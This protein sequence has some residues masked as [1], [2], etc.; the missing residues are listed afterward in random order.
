MTEYEIERYN[1]I[2]QELEKGILDNLIEEIDYPIIR[3]TDLKDRIINKIKNNELDNKYDF[4]SIIG[5]LEIILN[6]NEIIENS[7]LI[8]T[9]LIKYIDEGNFNLELINYVNNKEQ[10]YNYFLEKIKD[11]QYIIKDISEELLDNESFIDYCLQNKNLSIFNFIIMDEKYI[12]RVRELIE[13][14]YGYNCNDVSFLGNYHDELIISLLENGYINHFER[15]I[16]GDVKEIEYG[17]LDKS[18][19]EELIVDTIKKLIDKNMNISIGSNIRKIG[20]YYYNS[21]VIIPRYKEIFE[22]I[23]DNKKYDYLYIFQEQNLSSVITQEL[24]EK[25][26]NTL[27]ENPYLY[28]VIYSKTL[29]HYDQE[30]TDYLLD[31]NNLSVIN[32][33][34]NYNQFINH[35]DKL[36]QKLKEGQILNLDT[37]VV[38]MIFKT[39][40][41]ELLELVLNNH[42]ENLFNIM[43][44]INHNEN[45]ISNY[46]KEFYNIVRE[47]I[48]KIY[49]LNI[50]H[51]DKFVEK[52]GYE[53]LYYIEN[54]NMKKAINSS[55]IVFEKYLNL[56]DIPKLT[57]SDAR[58]IHD[59]I[60]QARFKTK[61]NDDINRFPR[62][63]TALTTEG[64]PIP[65]NDLNILSKNINISK[66]KKLNIL[67][68]EQLSSLETSPLEFI[69]KISKEIKDKKNQKDNLTILYSINKIYIKDLREKFREENSDT[70]KYELKLSSILDPVSLKKYQVNEIIKILC[71]NN[72]KPTK[73]FTNLPQPVN[74][75]EIIKKSFELFKNLKYNISNEV[76]NE[77]LLKDF[78]NFMSDPQKG[79][80]RVKHHIKKIKEIIGN[81]KDLTSLVYV[82]RNEIKKVYQLPIYDSKSIFEIISEVNID[83]LSQTV[84]TD[85]LLYNE[86]K[87][88]LNKYKFTY[89]EEIFKKAL[90]N[91][92]MEFEIYDIAT[93]ITKFKEINEYMRQKEPEDRTLPLMLNYANIL[94]S[95]SSRYRLIFGEEDNKLLKLNPKP[96]DA[97]IKNYR[98]ERLE[99][100]VKNLLTL[101]ERKSITVKPINKAISIGEKQIEVNLG[102][103]TN[104]I[105][106][107]YGERT[108]AC[109]RING[110][111]E[112]LYNFCQ[113]NPNAFHI[114][115][116]NPETGEFISRVSGFRNGNSIFLN[117]LRNSVSKDYNNEDVVKAIRQVAN[118]LIEES[119]DSKRKIDNVFI[120][121]D[122]AMSTHSDEVITISGNIK[123][124]LPNFYFDLNGRG[125]CLATTANDTDYVPINTSKEGIEEYQTL[126]DE[127][128]IYTDSKEIYE[129][130]NKYKLL[131]EMIEQNN[132]NSYEQ[133]ELLPLEEADK[134]IEL[135]AGEDFI[136]YIDTDLNIHTDYIERNDPRC[137]QELEASIK[138]LNKK[139]E[140]Y[141][142]ETGK[143]HSK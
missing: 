102:N 34:Y 137:H 133:T 20:N 126:R 61:Y 38:D 55:D 36:K 21:P 88:N 69:L 40:D 124:G 49:N 29:P 78:I 72:S 94:S 58:N 81:S 96:N 65:L 107:T 73:G 76:D 51:L 99:I 6:E 100:G 93:L 15:Y 87:Q 41:N 17:N 132:S 75:S 115:L 86:L 82:N 138:E 42:D 109:M 113:N 37:N 57:L 13:E 98:D 67:T 108:G 112:S 119:K 16:T 32:K 125:I 77:T 122:Y 46:N 27:K 134:V 10:Y 118:I 128:K 59:S 92:N 60:L 26:K 116:T 30:L 8:E 4:N 71:N 131:K 141:Q 91:S 121:S 117:E 80:K 63:K 62:I 54:N 105:N 52:F 143:G 43:N 136:A 9:I 33:I 31:H 85:D 142:N 35:K 56:F 103:F 1:K 83:E 127:V 70:Y 129:K 101:Y 97:P 14:G 47:R 135:V 12:D 74:N 18:I 95:S 90:D 139:K 106:L 89:W 23:L 5:F 39:N 22:Y 130:L 19:R 53:F 111:G 123:E 3:K 7:S 140:V 25:V 84:F 120:T 110:A 48:S 66:L 11:P 114:R 2:S 79:D 45:L 50:E 104:P 24:Y 68:E 28:E 64:L 44:Y